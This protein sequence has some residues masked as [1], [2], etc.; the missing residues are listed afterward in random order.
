MTP[1]WIAVLFGTMLAG[2]A[3][4]APGTNT[5]VV[6]DLAS[7]V[8]PIVGSAL[9]CTEIARPRVQTI[10][11]KFAAVIKEASSNEAERDD[12]TMLLNRNVAD[13][14]SAVTTGRIDCRPAERQLADL[15]RSIAGPA[16]PSLSG[17]IGPAS[18]AA[19]TAT[20]PVPTGPSGA[21]RS[22]I[23]EIRFGIA[24]TIFRSGKGTRAPDEARD[25]HR[26]STGSTTPAAWMAGCSG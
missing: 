24:A 1:R 25:R 3:N 20:A 13:G 16:G 23:D 18:A 11:D 22:P 2:A 4:A 12:L 9:A 10:V 17:V 15:E 7:R 6:R 19:A 21:R 26:L 8:G 5:N 14:R